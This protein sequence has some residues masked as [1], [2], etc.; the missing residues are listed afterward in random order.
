MS[1]NISVKWSHPNIA[2]SFFF[3]K[4]KPHKFKG[5]SCELLLPWKLDRWA[6]VQIIALK[7]AAF[8]SASSVSVCFSTNCHTD[9][10]KSPFRV[11]N[12]LVLFL[13]VVHIISTQEASVIMCFLKLYF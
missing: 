13:G 4:K 9:V 7:L 11:T 3:S 8:H 10:N 6:Q 1:R 12:I 2:I 5:I